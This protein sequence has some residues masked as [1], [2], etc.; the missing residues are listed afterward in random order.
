VPA[1]ASAAEPAQAV[2]FALDLK[3]EISSARLS[4]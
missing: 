3:E 2:N 4:S 1:S